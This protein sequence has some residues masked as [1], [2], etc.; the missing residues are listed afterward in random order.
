[1][2]NRRLFIKKTAAATAAMAM[3]AD[4]PAWAIGSDNDTYTSN[5][6]VPGDRTFTSKAV[7]KT[8]KKVKKGIS[9]PELSWMFENCFPNTLDTT[10]DYEMIDGKPDAFII[11]GDIDAMW[12]RD[13]TAQVWPYLPLVTQDD[14]LKNLFKGLI[15]RQ[16]KCILLDPYANAFFKD[17]NKETEWK[18]D[19]PKPKPGVHERKWEIDSLCY[20]IRLAYGYYKETGDTTV[21]DEEWKKASKLAV[22]TLRTEQ[23]KD[24]TSPYSFERERWN[25]SVGE[26]FRGTGRPIKPVG[27]IACIFRPSDDGTMYPFLVPSNLFA[28]QALTELSEIYKEAIGDTAFSRE[29]ADF[30]DEVKAAIETYAISEHLNYGKIYAYEVDGFGNKVFIDDPN[31]PSLVATR[32]LLKPEHYNETVYQ[33]TRKY[34]LSD[35]NPYY[36]KGKAGEGQGG[37]HAG[38]DTIWPMGIIL[39]AMT[40]TDDDEIVFCIK[41]LMNTHAGKGFMHETFHKDDASKFSR[42]W[43]AWAN[44][45]FGE[46]IVKLYNEKP[47]LLRSI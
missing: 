36:F 33:N 8:I 39:R 45:L 5:R 20:A 38:K 34:L 12:L 3:L 32:Y 13:S 15:N 18:D 25:T 9:N 42:S 26:P 23:R 30:S 11:T 10:V 46:L 40:S 4:T 6:P 22:Q 44:T 7:E 41:L 2:D 27:L 14:Q 1:M 17:V 37:P 35:D 43:F 47:A 19:K 31:I 21:F 28:V 29:C 16:T 24:G